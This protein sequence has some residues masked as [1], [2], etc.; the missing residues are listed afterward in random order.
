MPSWSHQSSHCTL[1][2]LRDSWI[3]HCAKERRLNSIR[4]KESAFYGICSPEFRKQMNL[5]TYFK[6][7]KLFPEVWSLRKSSIWSLYLVLDDFFPPNP[8]NDW[9]RLTILTSEELEVWS[10]KINI[11]LHKRGQNINP[12]NLKN[13][14]TYTTCARNFMKWSHAT[15][16]N[17]IKIFETFQIK[18]TSKG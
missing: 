8:K 14:F 16:H 9:S 17:K 2:R 6:S 5:L 1:G 18:R 10:M 3:K 4:S 7:R 13:Y 11:Y 15:I 12:V